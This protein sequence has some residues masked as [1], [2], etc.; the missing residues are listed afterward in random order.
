M[1]RREFLSLPR[2]YFSRSTIGRL[3]WQRY[4]HCPGFLPTMAS[5]TL[6]GQDHLFDMFQY[7]KTY[8]IVRSGAL[9]NGR[10]SL[11]FETWTEGETARRLLLAA[12][13]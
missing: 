9:D 13:L 2:L 12:G 7:G 1:N 11:A 3:L 5:P 8:L 6:C 10:L 4:A